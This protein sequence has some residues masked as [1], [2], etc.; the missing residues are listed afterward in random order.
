MIIPIKAYESCYLTFSCMNIAFY[1]GFETA[2]SAGYR[3]QFI[4]EQISTMS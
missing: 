4:K 2:S 3:L 1:K